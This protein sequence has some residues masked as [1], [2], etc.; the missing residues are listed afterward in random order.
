MQITSFKDTKYEISKINQTLF[1]MHKIKKIQTIQK[2]I[3]VGIH[4]FKQN[5]CD[6]I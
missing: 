2:E 6:R 5:K 1:N 3:F 4:E